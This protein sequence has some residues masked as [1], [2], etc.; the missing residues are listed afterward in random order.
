MPNSLP[1]SLTPGD[2]L[3]LTPQFSP[4]GIYFDNPSTSYIKIEQLRTYV[5]PLVIGF[6][7]RCDIVPSII[8]LNTNA[9]PP[10]GGS[11]PTPITSTIITG[12]VTSDPNFVPVPGV[13]L[14][15]STF[16]PTQ[17]VGTVTDTTGSGTS[18]TFTLPSG[19]ISIGIIQIPVN[20]VLNDNAVTNVIGVTSLS[21]YLNDTN[22]NVSLQTALA[23]SATDSQVT[24]NV[25]C[26]T[27]G[28][29]VQIA[30]DAYFTPVNTT[31]ALSTGVNSF[32]GRTG[33]VLP[34]S[35]DYTDAEVSGS[36]SNTLTTTG[37]LLIASAPNTLSRLGVGSG[38]EV[39]GVSGGLP[40]WVAGGSS[41][42]YVTSSL[43]SNLNLGSVA[44]NIVSVSLTSG[45][46]WLS[47]VMMANMVSD[48]DG[49]YWLG[50]TS[51]SA[52]GAYCQGIC[53]T[54]PVSGNP[55][56]IFSL[57]L[58]T[59]VVLTSPTT[60]YLTVEQFNGATVFGGSPPYTVLNALK[61]A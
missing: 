34:A 23:D 60:V 28:N 59:V 50:P 9:A 51:A 36:A 26:A 8:T 16:S 49:Y 57:P 55:Y 12:V 14:S 47:S 2:S 20:N 58:N 43:A 18:A 24:L 48:L 30:L 40:A 42:T 32:N 52:T 35:N 4:T 46:W 39:L 6:G 44:T 54:G 41:L 7:V 27:A 56:F 38:S 53:G 17:R 13:P 33:N 10:Q 45:T 61:I 29:P 15:T 22:T 25:T 3:T 5:P 21:K 19:T 1:F 11:I 37:D 31:S